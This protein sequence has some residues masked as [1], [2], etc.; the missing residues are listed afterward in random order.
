M[1]LSYFWD[2]HQAC[3]ICTHTSVSHFQISC[4]MQI[5]HWF[6]LCRSV[7]HETLSLKSNCI[8]PTMKASIMRATCFP[9]AGQSCWEAAYPWP[10]WLLAVDL[11]RGTDGWSL[12]SWFTAPVFIVLLCYL[13]VSSALSRQSSHPSASCLSW[14]SFS[15]TGGRMVEGR[16]ME[17]GPSS[18]T[19]IWELHPG[20]QMSKW[21]RDGG[22]Q[23]TWLSRSR[24]S[25]L[26]T[27]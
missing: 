15:R 8:C 5:N 26:L 14:D 2:I 11:G 22:N 17:L 1:L 3:V 16:Q 10:H 19:S 12:S 20:S 24:L 23:L 25:R 4:I 9:G 13:S 7:I 21:L 18:E 6:F 27:K